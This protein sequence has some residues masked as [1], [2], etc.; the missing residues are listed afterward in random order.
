M[1]A[2]DKLSK[3]KTLKKEY[4]RR[5]KKLKKKGEEEETLERA[6]FPLILPSLHFGWAHILFDWAHPL[7][8]PIKPF[9]PSILE[10]LAT[11]PLV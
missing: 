4:S 8:Q 1:P 7:G 10:D 5:K 6:F 2:A 11:L 9:K 3:K